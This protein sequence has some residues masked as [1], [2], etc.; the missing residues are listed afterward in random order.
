MLIHFQPFSFR[1]YKEEY[2]EITVCSNGWI[3]LG[4]TEQATFRNWPMP[5]PMGPSPMIAPFWDDLY[6]GS[7]NVYYFYDT[8]AHYYI[9]EWSRVKNRYDNSL[10]TFEV[11]FYDPNFYPTPL[12]DVDIKIQYHTV[13]NVDQGSGYTGGH[14]ATVGIESY[15]ATIGLEYTYNNDYPTAA[16][17]LTDEMAILFTTKLPDILAPPIANVEPDYFQFSLLPNSTDSSTFTISNYGEAELVYSISTEFIEGRNNSYVEKKSY[18][19]RGSGGPD[20][21]GYEWM[22]SNEPNGPTYNWRDITGMG[23]QVSFSHNDEAEGPFDIGFD[24]EY[25]GNSYDE[26][27]LNPNGWIGFGADNTEWSNTSI[28]SPDAPKP[29]ILPFWDDLHP[30]DTGGGGSGNVYYYSTSDSLIIWFDEVIHYVGT[31]NG[32]YDFQFIIYESGKILFQYRSME[33]DINTA[34]IGIQNEY[35]DDGLQVVYNSSYVEDNLAILF[36]EKITWIDY[37]PKNGII[38]GN[39]QESISLIA[40]SEGLE[41]GDYSCNLLIET[42][43]PNANL[44]TIPVDLTVLE[45]VSPPEDVT[46]NESSGNI[47]ITWQSVPGATSYKIYSSTEPYS[48]FT[49]DTSGNFSGTSW[50]APIEGK[51]KFYYVTTVNSPR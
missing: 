46:I 37:S 43:D 23:T 15:N 5:G 34:T 45:T 16:K 51:K 36:R 9:V 14:F 40:N 6:L 4:Q 2:N 48:G 25:Y 27:I 7:G 8:E 22:D 31:Y 42:N 38:E 50:T 24:F 44:L 11:I 49:L 13:N 17:E 12:N 3:A 32:T 10:E 33:G 41:L 39:E 26:F 35:G 20:D 18:N 21:Y 30:E 19:K 1:F 47:H 28:P 29:A